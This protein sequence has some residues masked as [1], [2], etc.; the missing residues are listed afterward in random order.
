M[1]YAS[2]VDLRGIVGDRQMY[3]GTP[4]Y[5]PPLPARHLIWKEDGGP[6]Q[7]PLFS[8]IES[9]REAVTTYKRRPVSAFV[10]KSGSIDGQPEPEARCKSGSKRG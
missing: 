10:G 2:V 6:H 7:T 9:L 1:R 8:P 5:P 3:R 4:P